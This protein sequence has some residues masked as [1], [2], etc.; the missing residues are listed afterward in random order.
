MDTQQDLIEPTRLTPAQ[1]NDRARRLVDVLDQ[2]DQYV[3][4]A[5]CAAQE[6]KEAIADLDKYISR[7]RGE[8]REYA[9]AALVTVTNTE[10]YPVYD[11]AGTDAVAG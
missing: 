5:K 7:L 10:E 3:V 6:S 4:A 9:I 1:V 11:E 8:I 2:R